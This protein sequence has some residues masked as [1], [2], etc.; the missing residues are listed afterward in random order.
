MFNREIASKR[1]LH[2]FVC[3]SFRYHINQEAKDEQKSTSGTLEIHE[4]HL[5]DLR[6]LQSKG[7]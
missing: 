5:Q 3:N 4:R 6:E 2:K 1:S 7:K